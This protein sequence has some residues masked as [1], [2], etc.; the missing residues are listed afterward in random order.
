MTPFDLEDLSHQHEQLRRVARA[1]VGESHADDVVQDAWTAALARR[2]AAP[3]PWGRWMTRG[4]PKLA[5]KWRLKRQNRQVRERV[6]QDAVAQ[7]S[8]SPEDVVAEIEAKHSLEQAILELAEPYR[9]VLLWRYYEGLT[10]EEVS[11]RVG[12][13]PS[14]TRTHLQRGLDRLRDRLKSERGQQWQLALLPFLRREPGALE[15]ASSTALAG[16]LSMTL[17]KFTVSLATVVALGA[18]L[19]WN[20]NAPV[21]TSK[22]DV[23]LTHSTPAELADVTGSAPGPDL[24]APAQRRRVIEPESESLERSAAQAADSAV[25]E[26]VDAASGLGLPGVAIT[27]RHSKTERTLWRSSTKEDEFKRVTDTT[28][29]VTLPVAPTESGDPPSHR[30][31]AVI[32]L[33]ETGINVIECSE[34]ALLKDEASRLVAHSSAAFWVRL[35]EE[36]PDAAADQITAVLAV[37]QPYAGVQIAGPPVRPAA[38][39][40]RDLL[41]LFPLRFGQVAPLDAVAGMLMI[42]TGPNG[43]SFVAPF[44]GLPGLADEALP[45]VRSGH[46]TH[47]F[48]VVNDSSGEGLAGASVHLR[49]PMSRAGKSDQVARGRADA[50]GSVELIGIPP[51]TVD[52]VLRE[53]GYESFNQSM[54]LTAGGTTELRLRPIV[55]RRQI[56]LSIRAKS[57]GEPRFIS[58]TV[59]DQEGRSIHR[60]NEFSIAETKRGSSWRATATLEHVP[61]RLCFLEVEVSPWT[62]NEPHRF[63]LEPGVSQLEVDLGREAPRIPV[64]LNL[65]ED[66]N[67]QYRQRVAAGRLASLPGRHSGVSSVTTAPDDGRPVT[68]VIDA[69]GYLPAYGTEEDWNRTSHDGRPCVEIKPALQAGWGALICAQQVAPDEI[70]PRS[71]SIPRAIAGVSIVDVATGKTLGVTDETGFAVIT[72]R[73][74]LGPI[75]AHFDG[76]IRRC[77]LEGLRGAIFNF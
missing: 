37:S 7:A 14:T 22:V 51:T 8:P 11:H 70:T 43:P 33:D 10:I 21:S 24:A 69:P 67:A 61:N 9:S 29:G 62:P 57:K 63:R 6:A 64:L 15:A 19:S 38:V 13:V 71:L 77:D 47:S 26:V 68:W 74:P 5:W 30:V 28:G 44:D 35:P 73:A 36:L 40:G 34:V 32:A 4:T 58:C 48:K 49:Q 72:A 45:A 41:M 42:A 65:P 59:Y 53:D 16:A 66:A 55:D 27:L 39:N 1:I 12:T 31:S 25:I 2:G 46:I 18:V 23:P 56:Q 75:E 50:N 20:L 3:E 17:T 76:E 60:G 54:T 52:V